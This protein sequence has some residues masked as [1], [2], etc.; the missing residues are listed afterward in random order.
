V[1]S[2]CRGGQ[3]EEPFVVLVQDHIIVGAEELLFGGIERDDFYFR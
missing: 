2:T 3:E 1:I